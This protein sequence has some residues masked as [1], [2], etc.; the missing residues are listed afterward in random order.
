MFFDMKDENNKILIIKF[1][2]ILFKIILN[3]II[4]QAFN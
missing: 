1:L 4:F 3:I 2:N